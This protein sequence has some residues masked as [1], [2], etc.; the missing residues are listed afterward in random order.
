MQRL[1]PI[2][3]FPARMASEIVWDQL[4]ENGSRLRV[5]DPM[6]GSGTT[7]VAA[8]LRGHEGIGYDSDRLSVLIARSWVTNITASEVH[9]KATEVVARAR[10]MVKTLR[11]R[12][13]YPT[14]ADPETKEFIR[15]WF[16]TTNRKHLTALSKTISRIQNPS[17]RD[18]MWCALSRL[19][20]T[21]QSGVSLAMDVSHSRPHKKYERAPKIALRHFEDE[22]N[23]ITRACPFTRTAQNPGANVQVADA[24]RLPLAD[25]SID[26]V[27]TSPPYLNAI[28]YVPRTQIFTGVD[29]RDNQ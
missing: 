4:P 16:D 14:G 2:H 19:I 6:S 15:Y 5:L 20:I 22:V 18:L 24:R 29:G 26:I 8:R 11:L 12:D 17:I 28:D 9:K 21:K 3:P 13:A 27:I 10:L 1:P 23:R 25:N 7:L